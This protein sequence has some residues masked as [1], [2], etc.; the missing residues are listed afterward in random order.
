MDPGKDLPEVFRPERN[1]FATTKR[2]A[3]A[4]A[5]STEP[6]RDFTATT[7]VN[8]GRVRPSA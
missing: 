4:P 7:G 3:P 2:P 6:H 1:I 5:L 8:E